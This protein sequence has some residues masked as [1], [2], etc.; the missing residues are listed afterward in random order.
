M[1]SQRKYK[2]LIN[3]LIAPFVKHGTFFRNR[4]LFIYNSQDGR[5]ANI[6]PI[7]QKNQN[8]M[9]ALQ[10]IQKQM[11]KKFSHK[12]GDSFFPKWWQNYNTW[13]LQFFAKDSQRHDAF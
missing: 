12:S 11:Q 3:I 6:S 7:S 9:S 1:S 4:K 2:V 8:R 10:K 13:N 5:L